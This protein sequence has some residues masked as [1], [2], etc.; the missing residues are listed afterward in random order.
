MLRGGAVRVIF[1]KSDDD[2]LGSAPIVGFE[3]KGEPGPRRR[4]SWGA[5]REKRARAKARRQAVK[6]NR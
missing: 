3:G 5:R 6:A 1:G 4:L 2:W